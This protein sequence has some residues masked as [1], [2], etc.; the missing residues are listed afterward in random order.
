MWSAPSKTKHSAKKKIPTAELP[1]GLFL[2][3]IFS[4]KF[5]ITLMGEILK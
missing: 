3:S 1:E 2:F 5:L 4:T